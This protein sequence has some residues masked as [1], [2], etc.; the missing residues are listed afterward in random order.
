MWECQGGSAIAGDDSLTTALKEVKEEVGISLVPKNGRLFKRLRR[1]YPSGGGDFLDI[2][3][4]KQDVNIADVVLAPDETCDV[5]LADV[6]KIEQMI[7]KG[8]FVGR[9]VLPYLDGLFANELS[10]KGD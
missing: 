6:A 10:P 7:D 8:I 5:M 2:W 1:D 9:D 3:I 4:F